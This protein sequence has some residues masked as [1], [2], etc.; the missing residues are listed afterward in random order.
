MEHHNQLTTDVL[1]V[2]SGGA[3]MRAAIAAHD[4]GA[5]VIVLSKGRFGVSGS[6]VTACADVSVDSNSVT[7]LLGFDGDLEDSKEQ[8]AADTV[9]SGGGLNN[10]SLV[11]IFTDQAPQRVKELID[12]GAKVDN[13]AISPGHTYRRAVIIKGKSFAHALARQVRGGSGILILEGTVALDIIIRDGRTAGVYAV[14]MMSGEFTT[15]LAKSIIIATGGAMNV[16]PITTAPNDLMGDGMAMAYRAGAKL[17]DME[18]Q[19]FLMGCCAPAS[20]RGN[21]YPFVL[22]CRAGAHL[23]NREGERFM[24]KWDPVRREKSTRDKIAVA[25]TLEILEGRGGPHG[26]V[27][28]SVRHIPRNLFEYYTQWYEG[29]KAGFDEKDFLPDLSLDGIEA[30]PSAHF[31]NGGIK[32]DTDCFTGIEGLY[33]AGECAGGIH[34]AN[35]LSGNAMSEILVTGN[36]A[37][38]SAARA[39]TGVPGPEPLK[40]EEEDYYKK[41]E[42]ILSG[43]GCEDPVELK[44]QLQKTAWET[45]GPVREQK[46]LERAVRTCDEVEQCIPFLS[47]HKG[48]VYNREWTDAITLAN[49]CD[50]IRVTA[51]AAEHR[52][53]SRSS[54]YRKDFGKPDENMLCNIIVEKSEGRLKVSD[55]PIS[56]TEGKV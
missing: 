21:N 22:M 11:E 23:Y 6:T 39:A 46:G 38:R 28:V 1:I 25:S 3:G 12:W 30:M 37:G 7:T 56:G 24:E 8:F 48:R 10:R 45:I 35:R 9:K 36:I 53:E 2:G 43:S 47:C 26:G 41:L 33:A 34:G 50:I 16:F 51:A 52:K 49:M 4:D 31:W 19:T 55:C 5:R 27:W 54:H 20:L 14:D 32:I 13:F 29:N 15:I 18:F 40:A 42:A 44:K 17:V